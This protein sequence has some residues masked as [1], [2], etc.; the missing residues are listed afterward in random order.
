QAGQKKTEEKRPVTDL[1][2]TLDVSGSMV[3][4]DLKPSR[5]QAA[6]QLLSEFLDEVQN[7]RVGL[8][9]FA[10]ISFTQCPLTTDVA[11]V[12]KLLANVE[13]APQSIKVD[14]TAI[15]DALVSS[16]NRLQT[17]I[18]K[19][20]ATTPDAGSRSLLSKLFKV[21]A[22]TEEEDSKPNSQAI[23]LLTDGANN[24]GMVDPLTAA[25]IIASRG[26]KI[27]AVGLGS[28]NRM[29]PAFFIRPD[30]KKVYALDQNGNL[31]YEEPLDMGLLKEIARITGGKA[32]NA[33]NNTTLKSVLDDIAKL[34]K[35]DVSVT[36]HWE[37]NELASYFLLAAFLLLVL[38]IGLETTVL[39]TLP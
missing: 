39:R 7:V 2:V 33:G 27:Y 13:P 31:I 10:R 3:T 4:D 30:G 29:I 5:I 12:K 32:Y 1:F 26:I 38:D 36:T 8:T 35:K 22:A 20:G 34:E 17:G 21:N 19:G 15:G 23:L 18:V 6:K 24:A 16:L 25:R 9:I 11:I 37:Y 28:T 14:G